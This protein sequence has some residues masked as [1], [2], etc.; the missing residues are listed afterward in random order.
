MTGYVWSGTGART[1][2]RSRS[3]PSPGPRF[4]LEGLW[5]PKLKYTNLAAS[6]NSRSGPTLKNPQAME[7][8][9]PDRSRPH[10]PDRSRPVIKTSVLWSS[11][12]SFFH[13][14]CGCQR[15]C[16]ESNLFSSLLIMRFS[17]WKLAAAQCLMPWSC[18]VDGVNSWNLATDCFTDELHWFISH[19]GSSTS[20]LAL[21]SRPGVGQ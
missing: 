1:S 6:Q 21:Y 12:I 18:P 11:R 13:Q 19:E 4:L 10:D 8:R 5:L 15:A 14:G 17:S 9:D 7:T 20:S 16:R 3:G 2:V